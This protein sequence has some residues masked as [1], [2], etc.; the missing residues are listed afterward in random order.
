MS[1][2][3]TVMWFILAAITGTAL[4]HTSQTVQAKRK[5]L[6]QLNKQIKSEEEAYRVLAAEWSHLNRPERLELL[7]AEYLGFNQKDHGKY[8]GN[9]SG[10]QLTEASNPSLL[11]QSRP[12]LSKTIHAAKEKMPRILKMR[13]ARKPFPK[14]LQIDVSRSAIPSQ[15]P[16]IPSQTNVKIT[17]KKTSSTRPKHEKFSDILRSLEGF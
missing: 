16:D 10:F 5:E 11:L 15:T 13:P 14:Q 3:I 8:L 12:A 17:P 1:K 7:A 4:F 2:K 9:S 6:Y